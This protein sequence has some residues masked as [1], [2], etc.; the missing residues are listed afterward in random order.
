MQG[1]SN[2]PY[3]TVEALVGDYVT[4][5]EPTLLADL[6]LEEPLL[7]PQAVLRYW[8]DDNVQQVLVQGSIRV[9]KKW[10]W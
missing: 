3:V 1:A 7:Q 10:H 5:A 9:R 2:F 8:V 4:E 6:L